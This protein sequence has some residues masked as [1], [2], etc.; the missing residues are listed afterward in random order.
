MEGGQ[1][2]LIGGIMKRGRGGGEGRLDGGRERERGRRKKEM[3]KKK[4]KKDRLTKTSLD[5]TNSILSVALAHTLHIR[6]L[7]TGQ[8]S[9][10]AMAAQNLINRHNTIH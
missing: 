2:A 6:F 4:V 1:K 10:T 9:S 3:E 7:A 8:M 5:S